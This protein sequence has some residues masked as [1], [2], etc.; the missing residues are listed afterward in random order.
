VLPLLWRVIFRRTM[1]NAS[2]Q[3]DDVWSIGLFVASLVFI[4]LASAAVILGPL[5]LLRLIPLGEAAALHSFSW[6]SG[7]IL[8]FAI[9]YGWRKYRTSKDAVGGRGA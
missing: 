8:V 4:G 6:V 7:M 2:P 1:R 3:L 5:Y 9:Y